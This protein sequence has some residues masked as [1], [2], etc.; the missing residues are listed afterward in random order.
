M[1]NFYAAAIAELELREHSD[2]DVLIEITKKNP[3]AYIDAVGRLRCRTDWR[4]KCTELMRA[5]KLVEAVKHCRAN[6]GWGLKEAKDAVE[7]LPR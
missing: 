5:G 2:R 4:R 6:T 7:A 3:K 1:P